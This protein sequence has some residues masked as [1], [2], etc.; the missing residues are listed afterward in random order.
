MSDYPNRTESEN[1]TA[2]FDISCS[3][4]WEQ[5]L[6]TLQA[7]LGDYTNYGYLYALADHVC[8]ELDWERAESPSVAESGFAYR[9]ELLNLV[10]PCF[11]EFY[12]SRNNIERCKALAIELLQSMDDPFAG[13]EAFVSAIEGYAAAQGIDFA[14]THLR[15]AY[16]GESCPMKLLTQRMEVFRDRSYDS[17]SMYK[18]GVITEDPMASVSGMVEAFEDFDRRLAVIADK[19][20]VSEPEI[21]TVQMIY[22]LPE[23]LASIYFAEGGLYVNYQAGPMIHTTTLNVLA[24]EYTHYLYDLASRETNESPA[25]GYYDPAYESWMNEAVAYYLTLKDDFQLR[26]LQAENGIG[27]SLELIAQLIGEEYDEPSDEVLFIRAALL[28][29]EHPYPYYLKTTNDACAAFGEYFVRTYGEK[30]F[31]GCML[32]PSYA[33]A[34]IGVTLEQ[35]VD[36]WCADMARGLVLIEP[37]I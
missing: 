23:N 5:A 36:D 33:E 32:Y 6:T 26:K 8:A 1:N 13:E 9:A 34:F 14:P 18:S 2:C 37:E 24:H 17:D 35:V 28:E 21:V 12:T 4:S 20:M 19:L 15:F 29:A 31:L 10:Y 3:G 30:E 11:D 16:N 7:A 27:A 25:G 22:P